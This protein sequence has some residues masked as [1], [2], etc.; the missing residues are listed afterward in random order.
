[1]TKSYQR[2]PHHQHEYNDKDNSSYEHEDDSDKDSEPLNG[3][4]SGKSN[5]PNLQHAFHQN[6]RVA[7]RS[8]QISTMASSLGWEERLERCRESNRLSKR[9]CRSQRRELT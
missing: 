3:N 2:D 4:P 5:Q 9:R 6:E 8:T 7:M 1:M